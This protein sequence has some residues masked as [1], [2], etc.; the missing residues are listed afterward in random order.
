M[1]TDKAENHRKPLERRSY[2]ENCGE[3]KKYW[4]DLRPIVGEKKKLN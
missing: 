1:K 2:P 3:F 4:D